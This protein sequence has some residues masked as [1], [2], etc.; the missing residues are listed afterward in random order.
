MLRTIVK[1][2][3]SIMNQFDSEGSNKDKHKP[4]IM[5]LRNYLA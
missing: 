1:S 5:F 2:T 3:N 4:I